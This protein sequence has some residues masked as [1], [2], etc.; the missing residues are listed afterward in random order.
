MN[1]A[2]KLSMHQPDA[3]V[4]RDTAPAKRPLVF[5]LVGPAGSG[6]T[7][8]LRTLGQ[9]DHGIRTVV[10]IP[11]RRYLATA[12]RLL[13]T[14]ISIHRP[15]RGLQWKEMKRILYLGALHQLLRQET[16]TNYRAVVLDEGPVYMLSR[17]RVFG[18]EAIESRTFQKWWRGAISEWADTIDGIVWLDAEDPILADRIRTRD[19]PYPV[20]DV[21]DSSVR[22]FLARYRA[23]FD[24]VIKELTTGDGPRVFRFVTD[25]QS[26]DQI[27]DKILCR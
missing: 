8:L 3:T 18:G 26:S 4:V 10:R 1:P 22:N 14:F 16:F 5:E 23:A 24:Y 19:Q 11:T 15:Y 13:P 17:L 2:G 12:F 27:A 20:K 6:K 9:R 25:G 21:S 7:T